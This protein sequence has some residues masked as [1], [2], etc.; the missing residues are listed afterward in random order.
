M[1]GDRAT[2]GDG[3]ETAGFRGVTVTPLER[4]PVRGRSSNVTLSAWQL[5]V[6]CEQGTGA[7]VLVQVTPDETYYRGAGIFLGKSQADLAAAYEALLPRSDE[8]AFETPQLG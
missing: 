5:G 7:I 2:P 4:V 3:K 1:N 6:A 8:P